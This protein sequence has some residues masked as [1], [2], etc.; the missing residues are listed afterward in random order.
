MFRVENN[1]PDVYVRNSRDFQLLSRLYTS[2]FAG[3]RFDS[4]TIKNI[5]N[6]ILANDRILDL[7][8]TRIGFFTNEVID[9]DTYRIIL[10]AFPYL[11]KNKGSKKG[12]SEAVNTIL[13]IE[14]KYKIQTKV[15]I[16][17][18]NYTINIYTGEKIQNKKALKALLEYI[19]PVGYTFAI[20]EYTNT[21]PNDVLYFAEDVTTVVDPTSSV[22]QVYQGYDD[23]YDTPNRYF[24]D[25]PVATDTLSAV[26]IMQV[27]GGDTNLPS[28]YD[29]TDH[30][31]EI[32]QETNIRRED[33]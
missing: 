28:T 30:V 2:V 23:E 7:I 13:K 21:T 16:D 8:A 32:L 27:V 4:G 24:E 17:N 22:S 26:G 10:K 5:I 11:I 12:I 33:N 14:G 29:T 15:N 3:V 25:K 18:D 6:P 19:V 9:V 31:T 1:V 20:E